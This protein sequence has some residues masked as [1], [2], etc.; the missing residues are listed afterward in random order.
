MD[1]VYQIVPPA[2]FCLHMHSDSNAG[3]IN[4]ETSAPEHM[5]TLYR[6]KGMR[7]GVQTNPKGVYIPG[8]LPN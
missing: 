8:Q 5:L 6:H 2:G 3:L 1:R 4:L 7:T